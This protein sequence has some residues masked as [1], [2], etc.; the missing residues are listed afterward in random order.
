LSLPVPEAT[1]TSGASLPPQLS[2]LHLLL[3]SVSQIPSPSV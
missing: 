2:W 1:L 3:F